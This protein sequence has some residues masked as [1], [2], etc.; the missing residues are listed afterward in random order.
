MRESK[1]QYNPSLSV[2]ENAKRNNVTEHAIRYYIKVNNIDRRFERTQNLIADC[3]KY[4]KKH[5]NATKTELH[6]KTGHSLSTIR[7]Y[8]EHITTEIEFPTSE[9]A[10]IFGIF[11][12]NTPEHI[13]LQKELLAEQSGYNAKRGIRN[14]HK[15]QWRTDWS[16]FNLDW[17]MYCL[18]HKAKE[19]EAF[20]NLLMAIPQGT[21][22]IEDVSFKPFEAN[23]ADL[24]GARNPEKKKFGKLAKKYAEVLNFKTKKATEA[25]EDRLLWDYCNVGVYEGKNVMG[26]ILMIIID[27][28]HN[29]TEPDIDYELLRSKYIHFLGEE[30]KFE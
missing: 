29:G 25:V 23:G 1:I 5:P 30:I 21:T 11:S 9:H 19:C 8:W 17:M 7:M 4:L 10:Y 27:C 13:S 28:L 20:R 14:A 16:D 15:S 18:W 26:K 6:E 3:R 2:K 22:I 12:H 24:W